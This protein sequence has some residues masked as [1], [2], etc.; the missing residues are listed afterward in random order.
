MGN[1]QFIHNT[2]SK[3]GIAINSLNSG[4]WSSHYVSARRV[5]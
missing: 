4:W 5:L 3:D 1:G 2:P